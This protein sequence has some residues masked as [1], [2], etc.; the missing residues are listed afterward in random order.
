[1]TDNINV[2]ARSEQAQPILVDL[3]K[4]VFSDPVAYL[5]TLKADFS[6]IDTANN[7][8]LTKANLQ[9]CVI[10]GTDSEAA[11]VAR[12]T[13]NHFDELKSFRD[14]LPE[15]TV[16]DQWSDG[17]SANDIE[18]VGDVMKGRTEAYIK[19]VEERNNSEFKFDAAM[20]LTYGAATVVGLGI[21]SYFTAAVTGV[22]AAK[23]AFEAYGD[24]VARD[25]ARQGITQAF[26]SERSA[27]LNWKEFS[28][29]RA[30]P[31]R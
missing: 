15:Y 10:N 6:K 19:H 3:S 12:E 18:L 26:Q 24:T 8:T 7:G 14:H 29:L 5:Q 13:L 21:Q 23:R 4:E 16:G 20:S 31:S 11:S 9:D 2:T 25:N 1:M 17:L 22:F 27:I 28:N 30:T